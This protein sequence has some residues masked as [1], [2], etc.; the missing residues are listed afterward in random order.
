M[1]LNYVHNMLIS[2][3]DK[4]LVWMNGTIKSKIKAKHIPYKK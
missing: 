2:T 1:R 3:D 4:G